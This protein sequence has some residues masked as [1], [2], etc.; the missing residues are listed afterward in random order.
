[1]LGR[2]PRDTCRHGGM[3]SA[4]RGMRAPA[5]YGP[6]HV[7]KYFGCVGKRFLRTEYH[8]MRC[9][10]SH[11]FSTAPVYRR[12]MGGPHPSVRGARVA[13]RRGKS[14]SI[15]RMRCYQRCYRARNPLRRLI[16][17]PP[18]KL[19]THKSLVEKNRR[20]ARGTQNFILYSNIHASVKPSSGRTGRGVSVNTGGW[21]RGASARG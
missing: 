6:A 9:V 12:W 16:A 8:G 7:L 14:W 13:E 10:L 18:G 15:G 21:R 19:R 2:A 20:R 1:V 4:L 11:N 3:N 17:Q 5:H